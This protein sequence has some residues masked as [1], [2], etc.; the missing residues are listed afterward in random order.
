M[1][2]SHARLEFRKILED[3]AAR[4]G[5]R[6]GSETVMSLTP[7]WTLEE[8]SERRRETEAASALLD[9]DISV[10]AGGSDSLRDICSHLDDGAILLD[11]K[12][13]RTVGS[14][15][16]GMDRFHESVDSASVD[17]SALDKHLERI[18]PVPKV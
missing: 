3:I 6:M 17:Y 18:P 11:P 1:T 13:L 9:N 5:S 7:G 8:A 12:Q 10:P 2:S 14:I 15:L 16:A 4:T